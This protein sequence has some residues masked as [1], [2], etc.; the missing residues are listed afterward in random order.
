MWSKAIV[1]I[2]GNKKCIKMTGSK[3]KTKKTQKG[4]KR[5]V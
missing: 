5:I 2:V 1:V 3:N 4:M